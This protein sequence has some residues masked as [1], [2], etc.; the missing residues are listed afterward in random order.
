MLRKLCFLLSIVC[1][2]TAFNAP[3]PKERAHAAMVEIEFNKTAD[4]DN[5]C[6]ATAISPHAIL[7]AA[8]CELKEPVVTVKGRDYKVVNMLR[9]GHD[10]QILILADSNFNAFIPLAPVQPVQGE[11][12]F[13]Y[14][15]PLAAGGLTDQYR[16]G[17]MSGVGVVDALLPRL[18]GDIF[19]M[20]SIPGDSGSA[21]FSDNG[22]LV[23]IVTG[24]TAV[25]TVSYPLAFTPE[26]I[27]ASK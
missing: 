22:D 20:L 18:Q 19:V 16:E 10:H 24:G 23:G 7:T 2:A 25:L 5:A 27:A 1:F 9:D 4:G 8:H 26:Q 11:H 21:I 3:S 13:F 17:Y 15:N 14:G 6:T 12:V